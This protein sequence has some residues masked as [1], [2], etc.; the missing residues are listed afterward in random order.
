MESEELSK[1]GT[2]TESTTL[3]VIKDIEDK[4]YKR[5]NSLLEP[6]LPIIK[7]TTCEKS[8]QYLDTQDAM[9]HLLKVHFPVSNKRSPGKLE[10]NLIHWIAS[11]KGAHIER[12]NDSLCTF[13][14]TVSTRV[15]KLLHKSAD[16]RNGVANESDQKSDEYLLPSALVKA[17]EKIFQFLPTAMYCFRFV[18]I[19]Y[20]S[21]EHSYPVSKEELDAN[22]KLAVHYSIAA[23]DA[24]SKAYDEL[25]LMSHTNTNPTTSTVHYTS[26]CPETVILYGLAGLAGRLKSHDKDIIELY[27]EHFSTLVSNRHTSSLPLRILCPI[28]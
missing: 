28:C 10:G 16:I 25:L 15:R 6:D 23:D 14:I 19:H 7:C 22:V 1:T 8:T 20:D 2:D 21:A 18:Q 3:Y 27:Q 5:T 11:I 24:L 4:D 12:R 17:A 9:E 13:I 26:I